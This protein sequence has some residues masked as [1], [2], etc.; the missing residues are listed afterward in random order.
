M[1]LLLLLI[2]SMMISMILCF[3][4]ISNNNR[5]INNN[6]N[7]NNNRK[8]VMKWSFQQRSGIMPTSIELNT[9]I[10]LEGE[11]YY[12]PTK[13]AKLKVPVDK[14]DIIG[15]EKIIPIFPAPNV[16]VPGGNDWLNVFEM[17]HRLLL[18]NVGDSGV[19]GFSYLST[20]QQKLSLVGT[21]AR[22]T[23]RK[24]LEDGRSFVVVEG[25]ERFYIQEIITDK[26]YLKAKVVPFKDY[27][28]QPHILDKLEN[29]IF[30]E[31]RCNVK[32]MEILF[33]Q[34]NYTL[35]PNILLHR[36]QIQKVGVRNVITDD[37]ME[38]SR[39]S[40]FSFAV[41]D[42]LQISPATKMS[43]LQEHVLEKRYSRFLKV[44]EKGGSYLKDELRNRG[45]L[46]EP[47]IKALVD[48]VLHDEIEMKQTWVAENYINGGW[49]PMATIM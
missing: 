34:K 6:N 8:L 24:I 29:D 46:T 45:V 23:S 20:T 1:K 7:N 47:G 49:M 43:L 11:Y 35:N 37:T 14:N 12:T 32:L 36:P 41:M 40:K 33:P 39:R 17:K 4:F 44:L 30:N 26:P 21:L 27:T 3:Q 9:N 28:E 5:V 25:L 15:K 38:L 31:V 19:F 16:L 22:I 2:L 10:G 18:N 48:E 13:I 42:M